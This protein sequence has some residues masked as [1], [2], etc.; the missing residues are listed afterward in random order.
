LAAVKVVTEQASP[1]QDKLEDQEAAGHPLLIPQDWVQPG[2][3]IM[4][5]LVYQEPHT[6]A[7]EAAAPAQLVPMGPAQ[8]EMVALD[9]R[10]LYLDRLCFMR[11]VAQAPLVAVLAAAAPEALAAA[12]MEEITRLVV[13]EQSILAAVAAAPVHQV[14][15]D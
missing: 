12:V 8:V 7:A 10:R 13:A 3:V 2:K 9:Y 14:Q 4:E 6:Q 1:W 5:V 15:Q 11:V